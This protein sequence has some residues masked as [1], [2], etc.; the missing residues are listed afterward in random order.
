M[1]TSWKSVSVAL[2]EQEGESLPTCFSQVIKYEFEYDFDLEAGK[3]N[4]S[5][6]DVTPLQEPEGM[7]ATNGSVTDC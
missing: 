5:S 7:M 4:P 2:Q 3:V 1:P 6:D